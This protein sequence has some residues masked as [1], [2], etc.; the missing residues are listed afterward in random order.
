MVV[1]GELNTGLGNVSNTLACT[2]FVQHVKRP[3]KPPH[4][5]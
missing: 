1:M 2:K 3:N 5:D 4:Q